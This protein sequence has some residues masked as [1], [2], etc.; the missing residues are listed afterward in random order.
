MIGTWNP[1]VKWHWSEQITSLIYAYNC[2]RN[3]ATSYSPYFLMF[4]HD[5]LLP[6]EVEF[7]IHAPNFADMTSTKYVNKMQK[8]MK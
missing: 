7:G 8:W 3:N 6:I 1:Q 4:G 2:T 5:P